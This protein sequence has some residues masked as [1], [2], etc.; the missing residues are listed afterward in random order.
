MVTY[1]RRWSGNSVTGR[2]GAG[3]GYIES[4]LLPHENIAY[5]ARLHGIVFWKPL[6]IVV[7]GAIFLVIQ[8]IIGMIVLAI[9]LWH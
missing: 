1:F 8:P 6:A 9:G 2:K 3:M 5:K 4:N 7:L